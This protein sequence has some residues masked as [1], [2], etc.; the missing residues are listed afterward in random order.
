MV[1]VQCI[2]QNKYPVQDDQCN[3]QAVIFQRKNCCPVQPAHVSSCCRFTVLVVIRQEE[4]DIYLFGFFSM[5]Q[6]HCQL[7]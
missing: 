3:C 5:Q 4:I 6:L 2:F 7:L 1:V